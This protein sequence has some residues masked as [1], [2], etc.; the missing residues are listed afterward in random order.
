MKKYKV[1]FIVM[2]NTLTVF[3][4]TTNP[5]KTDLPTILPPSPTVAALMKFEEVPVSNY[6]GVP[7]ISIPLFSSGTHSKDVN[8]DISLKYHTTSAEEVASDVGLGWSLFAGG[9][10]SRTVRGLPDEYYADGKVGIYHT[11]DLPNVNNYYSFINLLQNGINTTAEHYLVEEFQWDTNEKGKYDSEHDLWQF[12]FMNYTGRFII[13]KNTTTGLLEVKELDNSNLKIINYHDVSMTSNRYKPT[14]FAIFD[15]KGNKFIFD[16]AEI[17][18]QNTFT[19]TTGFAAGDVTPGSEWLDPDAHK[20]SIS[21]TINY[22]SAF[23]LSKIYDCNNQLIVDLLYNNDSNVYKEIV[24]DKT[25]KES[26]V[27]ND[28]PYAIAMQALQMA[29][30]YC[31]D[32]FADVSK[33]EPKTLTSLSKR[34]TTVKK[35]SVVNIIGKARVSFVFGQGREDNN[36]HNPS[37]AYYFKELVIKNWD[38]VDIKKFTLNHSYSTVIDKRMLLTEVLQ[39][40]SINN[41]TQT[42]KL[43][44][45]VNEANGQIIS[46]DYWGN[47]NLVPVGFSGPYYKEVTPN[48]ITTDALQKIQLPSKGCVIFDFESNNYSYE[49]DVALTNFDDNPNNWTHTTS[50]HNFSSSQT[51]IQNL[52]F[53]QNADQKITIFPGQSLGEDGGITLTKNGVAV[54][55]YTN[56]SCPSDFPDCGIEYTLLAGSQYGLKIWWVNLETTGSTSVKIVYHTRKPITQNW[57]YGGG[58][59]INRIGYFDNGSVPKDYYA[60]QYLY[61]QFSPSKENNYS[62]DFFSNQITSGSLVF[63]KPIFRYQ[64]SIDPGI[65][66]SGIPAMILDYDVIT[67]FNNLASLRTQGSDVGYKNVSVYETNNGK[68]NF[69]YTSPID[70]PESEIAFSLRPPFLPSENYDYKRGLVL[71][72]KIYNNQNKLLSEIKNNYLFENKIELTGIRFFSHPINCPESFRYVDYAHFLSCNT[73]TCFF[74]YN[75]NCVGNEATD[76]IGN[77]NI[78]EAYGWAK[79]TS[80]IAKNYFYP[81]GGSTQI[82]Q[83]DET[84]SYNPVNKQISEQTITNSVGEVLK[85][86]YTYHS[87]NSTFSQNR[88]SE[89]DKVETFRNADPITTTKINY[90][91]TWNGNVSYLPKNIQ[92]SKGAGTLENRVSYNLYDEFSNPLELQQE[93]GTIVS[94]I[95]GYNKTYPIAKIENATNAQIA[96]AL[97]LSLNSVDETKLPQINNLRNSL[98]STLITTYTYLPLIGITT[99]TDPKGDIIT[100]SYDAFGRLQ[101]VKDKENKILSENEYHYKP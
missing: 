88:I 14:S 19:E 68:T 76:F 35:L 71:E 21:P 87:G 92:N 29:S 40:N 53:N 100:Y 26:T 52:N 48:F 27:T 32:G 12:N 89:I 94:Y 79:L 59:R 72:E 69:I 67:S 15:D 56:I 16:I 58:I 93:K 98:P 99:I 25:F 42:Y 39:S 49:G 86:K 30:A 51:N 34:I 4:Q 9:T 75:T 5:I 17:T 96:T 46:K 70:Y 85:T 22:K 41:E 36:M 62:Y 8:L 28:D 60:N 54:A 57:L 1:L 11:S 31:L 61:G 24:T 18:N 91:T 20:T 6:T 74:P 38:N 47:F 33:M 66:C 101:Y 44:Y 64:T 82:V 2:I 90:A 43:D 63:K 78:L 73:H 23:H 7:D 50:T 45:I 37:D 10:I 80:K 65:H 81:I 13:K 55:S 77:K 84:Y 95:W 3:S 83:T 97:G